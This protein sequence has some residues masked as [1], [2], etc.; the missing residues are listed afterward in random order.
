MIQSRLRSFT[1]PLL[2]GLVAWCGSHLATSEVFAKPTMQVPSAELLKA[3]FP[4]RKI[5]ATQLQQFKSIRIDLNGDKKDE[6]ILVEDPNPTR[7]KKKKK[8]VCLCKAPKP[9]KQAKRVIKTLTKKLRRAVYKVQIVAV[10][11]RK[12][13][14][15]RH[16]KIW[17]NPEKATSSDGNAWMIAACKRLG[18][19]RRWFRRWRLR[20]I[21]FINV[22]NGQAKTIRWSRCKR[23]RR[24]RTRTAKRRWRRWARPDLP[25]TIKTCPCPKKKNLA[26]L[27]PTLP[28]KVTVIRI[29]PPKPA[30]KDASKTPPPKRRDNGLSIPSLNNAPT[31]T[32]T[33]TTGQ[34]RVMGSY[35]AD[36]VQITPLTRTPGIYALQLERTK[37]AGRNSART[38]VETFY[39]YDEGNK[40]MKKVFSLKTSKG[41]DPDDPGARQWVDLQLRNMDSDHWLEIVADIY[42]ENIQFSGLVARRM[43]K[44][45]NGKFVPLNT[46]RGIARVRASSTWKRLAPR[47]SR[48]L[49][50]QL[51][52]RANP[53]NLVDGFRNTVWVGGKGKRSV[54]DWVRIEWVRRVP[55]FGIAVF[56]KPTRQVNPVVK[57]LWRGK[58][59]ALKPARFVRIQTVQGKMEFP[60][61]EAGG[62][63]LIRFPQTIRTRYLRFQLLRQYTDPKTRRRQTLNIPDKERSRG[64]VAEIIPLVKETRYTASSFENRPGSRRVAS[65]A[66]DQRKSTAWA[67]GRSD[68]GIGEWLQMILPAPQTLQQITVINGCRRLGEKYI[69]NHRVKRAR[70]TFSNGS[71]Q[72][73]VLKDTHKP[74][75]VKFRSVRTR[76]V[77]LTITSIYKGKL[78]HTT[79]LTEMRP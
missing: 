67:E 1:T 41:N 8:K 43:F 9:K 24:Y 47:A 63:R 44:W 27:K 2:L 61:S 6:M 26:Y 23:F 13:I 51:R 19:K 77:R 34:Y 69:L 72:D 58:P 64:F 14:R 17:W 57:N 12:R 18:R 55:L 68:S 38:T 22:E 76:S 53:T 37:Q 46:Y 20:N 3:I 45:R 35:R 74:Q 32:A 59:P 4:Q 15:R 70:L 7:K 75:V 30:A 29:V 42:Y 39:I 56:T 52:L 40:R 11:K 28:M 33:A 78:G 65:Y 66:G 54:G 48:R 16:I 71:T 60:L 5:P 62:V 25:V 79:C 10:K 50:Q 21:T 31:G 36:N 49:K 73:V